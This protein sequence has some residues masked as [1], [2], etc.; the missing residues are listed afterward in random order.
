MILRYL[1]IVQCISIWLR[2]QIKTNNNFQ[3]NNN[4]YNEM[5]LLAHN[6]KHRFEFGQGLNLLKNV[7]FEFGL[8]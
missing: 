1:I 5:N 3:L 6:S 8:I 2:Y 4:N 7:Q